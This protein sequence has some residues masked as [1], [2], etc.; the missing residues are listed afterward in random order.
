MIIVRK[1]AFM[2]HI[3]SCII[4]LYIKSIDSFLRG[5]LIGKQRATTIDIDSF[6]VLAGTTQICSTRGKNVRGSRFCSNVN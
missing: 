4:I 6:P 2:L 3:F 5:I 1:N